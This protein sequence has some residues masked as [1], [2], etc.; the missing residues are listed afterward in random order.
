MGMT[1]KDPVVNIEYI[2]PLAKVPE[3]ETDVG[4]GAEML[5]TRIGL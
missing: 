2:L 4:T 5:D 1:L 3:A